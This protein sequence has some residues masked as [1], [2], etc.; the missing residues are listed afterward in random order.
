MIFSKNI[1][2][3]KNDRMFLKIN[4]KKEKKFEI[5]MIDFLRIVCHVDFE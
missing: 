2:N 5:Y 4:K 3:E 1:K